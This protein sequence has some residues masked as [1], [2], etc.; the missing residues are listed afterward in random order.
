M[1]TKSTRSC[2]TPVRKPTTRRQITLRAEGDAEKSQPQYI[3]G[4]NVKYSSS[5]VR[6]LGSSLAL[7]TGLS[8]YTPR[9]RLK[10]NKS[11][12]H[13]ESLHVNVHDRI[14]HNPKREAT[15]MFINE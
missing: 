1:K 5:F 7:P 3:I 10:G 6:Q 12:V 2:F 8:N 9:Y 4:G 13:I 15:Q 11:A 14:I